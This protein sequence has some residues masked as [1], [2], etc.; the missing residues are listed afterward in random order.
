MG[1]EHRLL[2]QTSV[3]KLLFSSK[4]KNSCFYWLEQLL[5]VV[6]LRIR[7]TMFPFERICMGV[8][9]LRP[10]AV[11]PGFFRK[12]QKVC[13]SDL[14]IIWTKLLFACQCL[15][16]ISGASNN[17]MSHLKSLWMFMFLKDSF[18]III[19]WFR[20]IY[21]VMECDSSTIINSVYIWLFHSRASC[22]I[23]RVWWGCL[24]CEVT[25]QS[26]SSLHDPTVW[27]LFL[28]PKQRGLLST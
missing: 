9:S 18:S 23:R 20:L 27:D 7:K 14:M 25:L 15:F 21:Q 8:A 19:I 13:S 4:G 26:S 6:F 16:N 3:D 24:C 22:F 2:F 12:L 5:F 28:T 10:S 11:I 1:W 17:L